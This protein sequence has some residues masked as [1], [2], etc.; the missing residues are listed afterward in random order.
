MIVVFLVL[1]GFI[2]LMILLG[3]KLKLILLR[4]CLWLKFLD[5]FWIERFFKNIYFFFIDS[6][7]IYLMSREVVRLLVLFFCFFIERGIL[8]KKFCFFWLVFV[9]LFKYLVIISDFDVNDIDE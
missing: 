6:I 5:N 9:C 4:V 8:N 2:N 7:S 3:D 1:L